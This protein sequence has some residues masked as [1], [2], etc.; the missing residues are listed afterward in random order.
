MEELQVLIT[1][2]QKGNSLAYETIVRR[3]Q[4]MAVGYGYAL[5]GDQTLAEIV[6][7]FVKQNNGY[8]W[9]SSEEGKGTTFQVY[10]PRKVTSSE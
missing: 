4:D 1:Q 9:V 6:F 3:F 10:L 2:A 7:D 8:I 5:L